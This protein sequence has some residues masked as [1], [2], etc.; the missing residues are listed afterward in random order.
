MLSLLRPAVIAS[1]VGIMG[2]LWLIWSYFQT[3]HAVKWWSRKQSS[4]LFH[5]AEKIRDGL[6]QETFT[7]RR[8]LEL[9][10]VDETGISA[11]HQQ[12][13]LTKLDDWHSYLRKLSDHL[14]PAYIEDSLPLAIH[15]LIE[16]WQASYP[17]LNF[18]SELPPS[19]H[20]ESADLSIVVLRMLDELL[21]LNAVEASLVHIGLQAQRSLWNQAIS[22]LS[23]QFVYPDAA[24]LISCYASRDREY[25]GRAFRFL[26]SGQCYHHKKNLTVVWYFRWSPQTDGSQK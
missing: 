16:P 26:A 22:E 15:S 21:Q 20:P 23:V 13:W 18:T 14:S 17:Q 3:Q 19:W 8:R 9:S 7:M 2:S 5:E 10:L 25:L 4:Q 24:A 11:S 1:V 6:L 12:N